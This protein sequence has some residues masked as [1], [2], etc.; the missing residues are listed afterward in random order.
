MV[1]SNIMKSLLEL[2]LRKWTLKDQKDVENSM[3]RLN[4]TLSSKFSSMNS[5]ERCVMTVRVAASMVFAYV[6]VPFSFFIVR[7]MAELTTNHLKEG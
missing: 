1:E 3:A 4:K 6:S 2:S 7:Y 5:F